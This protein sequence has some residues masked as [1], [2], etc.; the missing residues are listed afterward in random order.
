M[1]LLGYEIEKRIKVIQQQN[2]ILKSNFLM[3]QLESQFEMNNDDNF[4][5]L[6]SQSVM[7]FSMVL[8]DILMSDFSSRK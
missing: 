4:D 7:D 8:E 3:E 2:D 5:P 1:Q 6:K